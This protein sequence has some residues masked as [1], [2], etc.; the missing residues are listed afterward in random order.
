VK[1]NEEIIKN[2]S[3]NDEETTE[4]I[5]LEDYLD[6]LEKH[7]GVKIWTG[8]EALRELLVG[9]DIEAELIKVKQALREAPQKVNQEKLKFLQG[10]QKSGLKLE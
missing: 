1:L 6:F 4:V 2:S 9:I 7:C 8:A 10:L 5:F 3:K